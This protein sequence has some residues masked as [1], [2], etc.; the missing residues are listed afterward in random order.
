MSAHKPAKRRVALTGVSETALLTL[1]ARA[2][3]ARRRDAIIDDGQYLKIWETRPS[4]AAVD[5]DC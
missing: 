5:R 3:E 4:T 2:A 1:N